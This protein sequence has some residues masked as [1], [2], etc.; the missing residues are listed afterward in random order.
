VRQH[1][2]QVLAVVLFAIAALAIAHIV[3]VDTFRR[4][5]P[6][7]FRTL[8]IVVEVII[9]G[10]LAVA[11]ATH[12]LSVARERTRHAVVESLTDAF[13]VPRSI[14]E[15]G[16]VSVAQLVG[17]DVAG[18]ALLAVAREDGAE[19]EPVAACGYPRDWRIETRPAAGL[20][21]AETAVRQE[22]NLT[23][24][25]LEPVEERLGQQ[26]WVARVP[27]V[28]GDEVFG[29]LLLVNPKQGMLADARLLRI[30]AT[31]IAAALDHAQLYVAAYGPP[32]TTAEADRAR[33][34][35]LNAVASELEP[36]LVTVE[37]HAS[38]VAGDEHTP[39][40]IED[41]RHLSSLSRSL[42]RLNLVLHDLI[43]LG[44]DDVL[45]PAAEP[46]TSTDIGAVLRAMQDVFAPAFQAH[47]QT[48]HIETSDEP[49]TA[50]AAPEPVERML[51][52]LLSNATRS[53]PEDGQV[54][55]RAAAGGEWVRIEVEDSGPG[56]DPL[57][58]N[59]VFEPFYRVT[60]GVAEVPGAGLGLAVVG[61]LAEAQGGAVRAAAGREG[62]TVYTVELPAL[63]RTASSQA[64]HVAPELETAASG[65]TEIDDSEGELPAE[66][67]SVPVSEFDAL[68]D[69]DQ[70]AGDAELE[71]ML[72]AEYIES[73]ELPDFGE[74]GA[75]ETPDDIDEPP[76]V[77]DEVEETPQAGI[78]TSEA[79]APHVDANAIEDAVLEDLHASSEGAEEV[80]PDATPIDDKDT[81]DADQVGSEP[82]PQD[83]AGGTDRSPA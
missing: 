6:D 57:E 72:V 47:G 12:L 74:I 19:L 28:S 31:L 49:L 4:E 58:G 13:S 34:D 5:A 71:D 66:E 33:H 20:V 52:H 30:V 10:L 63:L 42:E 9:A 65:M 43:S 64:L 3:L 50:L 39:D 29:L 38:V 78:A 73:P 59:H 45:S 14:E 2:L 32:A 75:S 37:A 26:P 51:L 56:L 76:E 21:P 44:G 40:T 53:A 48:L 8:V 68:D 55:V 36:A 80:V 41:A 11:A 70:Q 69:L 77:I 79:A 7:Q 25:W 61:R 60:P 83:G 24:P 81:D 35:L 16:Q 82:A 62:G 46:G 18:A 54:T 17:A 67:G 27:I 15:I 22:L 23:D 1:A